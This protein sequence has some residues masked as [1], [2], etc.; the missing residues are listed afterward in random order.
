MENA[1][2]IATCRFHVKEKDRLL[3]TGYFLDNRPDGN[4]IEI[5]LEERNYFIQRM[6]PYSSVEVP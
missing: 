3:I 4:R 1:F 5:R 6:E 2:Y